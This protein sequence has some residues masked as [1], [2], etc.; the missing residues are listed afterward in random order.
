MYINRYINGDN[1]NLQKG[2]LNIK[3]AFITNSI[4]KLFNVKESVIVIKIISLPL[5]S[6][7]FNQYLIL[8]FDNLL[9]D[10]TI[11]MHTYL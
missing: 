11:I 1:E 2:G 5:K 6:F 10:I 3:Q 9:F 8:L 7:Y 4:K